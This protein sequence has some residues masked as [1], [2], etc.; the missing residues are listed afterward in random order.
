MAL[1]WVASSSSCGGAALSA[2]SSVARRAVGVSRLFR[3][4][5]SQ[6]PLPSLLASDDQRTDCTKPTA[7]CASWGNLVSNNSVH[8]NYTGGK[9][10]Y[11]ARVWPVGAAVVELLPWLA[12]VELVQVLAAVPSDDILVRL[13]GG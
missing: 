4:I 11:V 10:A 2:V 13:S 1:N 9:L 6:T 7:E 3:G 8:C 5:P 12:L